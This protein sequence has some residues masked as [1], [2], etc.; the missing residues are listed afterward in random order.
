MTPKLTEPMEQHVWEMAKARTKELYEAK[1][2]PLKAAS[3]AVAAWF[4]E[5]KDQFASYCF[6]EKGFVRHRKV[7]SNGAENTNSAILPI[8]SLPITAMVVS[9]MTYISDTATDRREELRGG[10][11]I[12]N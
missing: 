6:L 11:M 10:R 4:D 3:P 8:R 7:T 2:E 5:R 12:Q 1:L 9:L